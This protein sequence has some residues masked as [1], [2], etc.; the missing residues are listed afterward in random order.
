VLILELIAISFLVAA[1]ISIAIAAYHWIGV[2]INIRP[3]RRSLANLL[4]P[5]ILLAPGMFLT[6]DGQ[7]H[8][9]LGAAFL[10]L[11]GVSSLMS[12]ILISVK[13]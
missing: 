2:V 11:G 5:F 8:L 7:R 10:L 3:E 9:V 4:S 12:L 6:K 13:P 1:I